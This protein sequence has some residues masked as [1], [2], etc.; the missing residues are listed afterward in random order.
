[1][2]IREKELELE[3]DCGNVI[4]EKSAGKKGK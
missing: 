3:K 1:M 4:M 2:E